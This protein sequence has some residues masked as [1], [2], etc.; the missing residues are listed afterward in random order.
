MK[1]S[2]IAVWLVV[3]VAV[4][5]TLPSGVLGNQTTGPGA[6][7]HPTPSTAPSVLNPRPTPRDGAGM[8]YDAKEGYFLLF[9]GENRSGCPGFS[10]VMCGDTWTFAN[11]T[12]ARLN[13]SSTPSPRTQMGMA[14]N[15]VTGRVVLFGGIAASG[16]N[17]NDTWTFYK[18]A[19]TNV[20]RSAGSPPARHA[21]AM[22]FDAKDGYVLMFGGA[23][24]AGGGQP[25]IGDT[26]KF[27]A[28][29]YQIGSCGGPSQPGCNTSAPSPRYHVPSAYDP[30]GHD[31]VTFGG[32]DGSGG[33]SADTWTY[34]SGTW[35]NLTATV[36]ASPAPKADATMAY[37]TA[38]RHVIL[39]GGY[40]TASIPTN[41]TWEYQSGR[42]M[43]L[44]PNPSPPPRF[45]AVM[46]YDSTGASILLFGGQCRPLATCELGDTW[47]YAA[48]TWT[49][50]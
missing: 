49:K 4:L 3:G 19:W 14:Y 39:F 25:A 1:T 29:W 35:T 7:V 47:A 5:L 6:A 22:T 33:L 46:A 48:G 27:R 31:V 43:R 21:Q 12:W 41:G 20:T 18:G 30:T 32:V 44:H 23:H 45:G 11:G 42:W 24:Q 10:G 16:Y 26:W 37:S 2:R 8:V 36:G 15:S 9:G 34:A 50:L 17:F 28:Y 38:A 40:N 13:L